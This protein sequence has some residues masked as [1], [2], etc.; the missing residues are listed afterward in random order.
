VRYVTRLAYCHRAAVSA[1]TTV[2]KEDAVPQSPWEG[3]VGRAPE[4]AATPGP[5]PAT[6]SVASLADWVADLQATVRRG[7]RRRRAIAASSAA[8]LLLLTTVGVALATDEPR[9]RI[10]QMV[11]PS[12][13]TLPVDDPWLTRPEAGAPVT[14][15]TAAEEPGGLT[16][17]AHTASDVLRP[18]Q[19]LSVE[20]TWRDEDGRLM[21]I[22]R[23][24]GD[25][26][27]ASA[28]RGP[29]CEETTGVSGGST[30]YRHTYAR[31]GRYVV[32]LAVTT[33]TCDGLTEKRYVSFPVQVVA[34]EPQPSPAPAKTTKPAPTTP[35]PT[36][37]APTTPTPTTPT[38][39][40]T[41][42]V[43]TETA[44]PS[45]SGSGSP[46]PSE[47]GP[48]TTSEPPPG[49]EPPASPSSEPPPAPDP[50]N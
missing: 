6:D 46:S 43:P 15:V 13:S 2:V 49:T 18:G 44:G 4:D 21:D 30:W 11:L 31:P 39:S 36:T 26:T 3:P 14:K 50:S 34:P 35:A 33:V 23:E 41:A 1:C 38:G 45:P 42:P 16:V 28:P 22:S 8:G 27:H 20:L 17:S 40:P 9:P 32:R 48:S 47:A 12:A 5:A 19:A 29:G 7:R 24:W 10:P 37:P 25:G